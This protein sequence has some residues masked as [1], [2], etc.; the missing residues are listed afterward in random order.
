MEPKS[1][2]ECGQNPAL[3][4]SRFAFAQSRG[5]FVT[6]RRSTDDFITAKNQTQRPSRQIR[7]PKNP[8]STQGRL[9]IT[10]RSTWARFTVWRPRDDGKLWHPNSDF[11]PGSLARAGKVRSQTPSKSPLSDFRQVLEHRVGYLKCRDG[12]GGQ[13]E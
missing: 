6:L 11:S 1:D 12:W 3:T 8:R 7:H 4:I 5:D 2:I 10:F 9:D 13:A